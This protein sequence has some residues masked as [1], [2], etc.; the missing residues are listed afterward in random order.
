MPNKPSNKRIV[1]QLKSTILRQYPLT[2][3]IFK[4]EATGLKAYTTKARIHKDKEADCHTLVTVKHGEVEY[5]NNTTCRSGKKYYL[6]EKEEGKLF[7][8]DIRNIQNQ[9]LKVIPDRELSAAAS[10]ERT[11]LEKYK[12]DKQ[13]AW[14]KW[15]NFITTA[16]F[17]VFLVIFLFQLSSIAQDLG[18]SAARSA[19][20]Y[21]QGLEHMERITDNQL[22]IM[23]L[24]E[25]HTGTQQETTPP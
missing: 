23:K 1:R 20:T 6:L 24:L 8:M 2:A 16:L 22:E 13:G 14:E 10:R 25:G 15:G 5:P 17:L 11:A 21:Q 9:K 7:P 19:Q 12:P 3:V 18:A 4:E